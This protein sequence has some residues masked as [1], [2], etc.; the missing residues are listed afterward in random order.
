MCSFGLPGITEVADISNGQ[1]SEVK[2]MGQTRLTQAN[3]HP[4]VCHRLSIE[5]GGLP[6]QAQHAQN[7]DN[8][9][10]GDCKGIYDG[11]S[12]S[13]VFKILSNRDR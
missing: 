5:A 10:R 8:P 4:N 3:F 6:H 13:N 1:L 9:Y 7:L 2:H 11:C 12:T